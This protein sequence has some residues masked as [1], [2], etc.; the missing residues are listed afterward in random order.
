MD[1][2]KM[3]VSTKGANVGRIVASVLAILLSIVVG[4]VAITFAPEMA[5]RGSAL[6]MQILGGVML[7]VIPIY[8]LVMM[9]IQCRSHLDVYENAV[10]GIPY[11]FTNNTIYVTYDDILSVELKRGMIN[12]HTKQ[13]IYSIV[14]AKNKDLAVSEIRS[15]IERAKGANS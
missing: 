15:R 9:F 11:G 6:P 1:R 2:G 4:A 10:S 8:Q 14:P 7:F 12:L 5:G 13:K 3:I